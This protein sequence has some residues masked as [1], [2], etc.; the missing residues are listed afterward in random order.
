MRQTSKQTVE[1][2]PKR[3]LSVVIKFENKMLIYSTCCLLGH[4]Y[5]R[6]ELAFCDEKKEMLKM[7]YKYQDFCE[8]CPEMLVKSPYILITFNHLG[9]CD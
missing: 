5:H 1:R 6:N 2:A 7:Y 3:C 8:N 4:P 9:A